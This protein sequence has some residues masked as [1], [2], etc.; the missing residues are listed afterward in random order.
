MCVRFRNGIATNQ[1]QF[2][3][4]CTFP[5]KRA[6]PVLGVYPSVPIICA[7]SLR[8]AAAVAGSAVLLGVF[9]ALAHMFRVVNDNNL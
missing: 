8:A 4:F 9:T 6:L 7:F 2:V 3:H 1:F 5:A